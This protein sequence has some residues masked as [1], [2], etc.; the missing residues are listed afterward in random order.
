MQGKYG[1][2]HKR[3]GIILSLLYLIIEAGL[4]GGYYVYDKRFLFIFALMFTPLAITYI[5]STCF[6][7]AYRN[8]WSQK[9][10]AITAI[11]WLVMTSGLAWVLN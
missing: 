3:R 9:R 10:W 4:L 8:T 5:A 6:G 1:N 7:A 11:A 2:Y